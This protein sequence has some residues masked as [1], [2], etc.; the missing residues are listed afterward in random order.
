MAELEQTEWYQTE[1]KIDRFITFLHGWKGFSEW[2]GSMGEVTKN[3]IR[4]E[5][6]RLING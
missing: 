3:K 4:Q 6:R 1:K 2:W 5:I